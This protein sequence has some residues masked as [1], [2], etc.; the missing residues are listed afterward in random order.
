MREVR[1]HDGCVAL[2]D[3]NDDGD[4]VIIEPVVDA[5]IPVRGNARCIC[6]A[7]LQPWGFRCVA[8]DAVELSCDRCH[9]IFG[10]LHLGA[11]VHR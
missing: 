4:M 5:F 1:R 7:P 9:R 11:R 10:H 2:Y 6:G 3:E 8:T